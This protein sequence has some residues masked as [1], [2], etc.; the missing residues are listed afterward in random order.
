MHVAPRRSGRRATEREG[1][2]GL[3]ERRR[4]RA[5]SEALRQLEGGKR[6]LMSEAV[7]GCKL[8]QPSGRAAAQRPIFSDGREGRPQDR[9]RRG[10]ILPL[11]ATP[12]VRASETRR[13]VPPQ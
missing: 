11:R 2:N 13:R 10:P 8:A 3:L 1:K 5:R 6:V 7:K 4:G 12:R 9:L